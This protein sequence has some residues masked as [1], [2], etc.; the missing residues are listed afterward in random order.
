MRADITIAG[1]AQYVHAS[2][3]LHRRLEP[4][5]VAGDLRWCGGALDLAAR[6][7]LP[8][9]EEDCAQLR[10]ESPP[11]ASMS[12]PFPATGCAGAVAGCAYVLE[13]A[14]LGAAL[15]YRHVHQRLGVTPQ[16]GARFV[17]GYGEHT[18]ARWKIFLSAL[19][20]LRFDAAEMARCIEAAIATFEAMRARFQ[21]GGSAPLPGQPGRAS[22]A[23][24]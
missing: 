11:I 24:F 3:D 22:V 21:P 8:W 2:H 18:G 14:T 4:L 10:I 9:L 5:L 7:K 17:H 12:G 20:D 15:I 23:A 19:D 6:R 16:A 1:Y 13:G